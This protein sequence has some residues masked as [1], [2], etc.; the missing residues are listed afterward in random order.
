MPSAFTRL[1][2]EPLLIQRSDRMPSAYNNLT[3]IWRVL[4]TAAGRQTF[5]L[6]ARRARSMIVSC[7]M[8]AITGQAMRHL[9][10]RWLVSIV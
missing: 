8:A 7:Q 3:M 10:T 6:D 2:Q 5:H 9:I 4:T 1:A